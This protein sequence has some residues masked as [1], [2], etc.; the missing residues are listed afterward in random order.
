VANKYI[1]QEQL[2][3]CTGLQWG[4]AQKFKQNHWSPIQHVPQPVL[5]QVER[6]WRI[7]KSFF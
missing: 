3:G 2:K 1:P 6:Q 7:F 4:G 5:K